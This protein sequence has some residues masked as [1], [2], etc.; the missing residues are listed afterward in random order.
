MSHS[1]SQP[2][3]GPIS[4]IRVVEI[5]S[6][7]LGPLACQLLG[8][9]GAEVI[10]IEPLFGDSNR[11]V[12]PSGASSDLGAFFV[13]CN[14]NKRS[15]ALDLKHPEGHAAALAVIRD[16]DVLVH[17]F[18]PAAMRRLGLDYASVCEINPTIVYCATY[19]FGERGPYAG[20]GAF[21]DTIQAATG[22]AALQQEIYGEMRYV[23][24]IVADK[25]TAMAVSQAVL[26]ALFHRERSGQGQ[27][28]EVP[29]FETV[30]AWV[31]VE[32][33][34]GK[35]FEPAVEGTGY[36][37]VLSEQRKPYRTRDGR[38]LCIMPYW[39]AHWSTFCDLC[40]HPELK[41]DARFGT[42]ETRLANID[43]CFEMIG[44]IVAE[45][46]L[47]DWL[48]I[49]AD[50]SVP[51]MEAKALDDLLSD[52]HLEAI[53]FWQEFDH[54]QAGRMRL[55]VPPVNFSLTPAGIH[56]LPPR[57]GEH[58]VEVLL[59]AGLNRAHVQEL[60]KQG[61]IRTPETDHG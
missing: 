41:S 20:R 40:G 57:L 13:S 6:V 48:A 25:T 35:S 30:T 37:R 43:Q 50:S 12:G 19:G 54:P 21:D 3:P 9:L 51:V 45:R 42:I 18:R 16:A 39:D 24:T 27:E 56:R 47:A 10:K 14:R 2:K 59:E 31:M 55:S 5:A 28:I 8:D 46:E 44:T 32:H 58:S 52:P 60:L 1:A 49:F 26:A 22:L 61:I 23:P 7:V 4:G 38:Y 34:W 53:G 11:R 17:N 15:L 29:M 33:L 36:P